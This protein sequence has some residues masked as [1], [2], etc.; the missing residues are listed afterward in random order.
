MADRALELVAR[1]AGEANPTPSDWESLQRA[2]EVAA[3]EGDQDFLLGL[4]ARAAV[5]SR[6]Q[7]YARMAF[8]AAGTIRDAAALRRFLELARTPPACEEPTRPGV[9]LPD[10][11][12]RAL[13]GLLAFHQSDEY[14]ERE[15]EWFGSEEALAPLFA[16][17]VQERVVRGSDIGRSPFVSE[18]WRRLRHP[19]G[20]LPLRRLAIEENTIRSSEARRDL[21]GNWHQFPLLRFGPLDHPEGTWRTTWTREPCEV[22]ELC[23]VQADAALAPNATLDARVVRLSEPPPR[24]RALSLRQFELD[25]LLEGETNVSERV[26]REVFGALICLGTIGGAYAETRSGAW[27]RLLAWRSLRAL[28]GAAPTEPPEQVEARA[29]RCGWLQFENSGRW[30]NRVSFDLGLVCVRPD[31]TV[32]I[33]AMT[34]TD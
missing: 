31:A 14:L 26:P 27:G 5:V 22:S 28:V 25:A 23:A 2:I 34:D 30:F 4:H 13:G 29:L 6:L 8:R 12:Q 9:L 3:E 33:V 15:L 16:C 17:W 24:L 32:A 1:F 10:G 18:F 21:L 19:L 7:V 20:V 11:P